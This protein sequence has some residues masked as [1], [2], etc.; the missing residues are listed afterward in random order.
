MA[1]KYH[2]AVDLMGTAEVRDALGVSPQRVHQLVE[3]DNNFPEPVA[4]LK[5]G[6]I[7]LAKDVES[8]ARRKA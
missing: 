7:W 1:S 6:R 4:H 2:C 8:W 5:C 3:E